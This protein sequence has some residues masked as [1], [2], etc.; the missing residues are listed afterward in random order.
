MT[1][2]YR[3]HLTHLTESTRLCGSLCSAGRQPHLDL[4]GAQKPG[5]N[6]NPGNQDN[7]DSGDTGNATD[8]SGNMI[9][10]TRF[11]RVLEQ[12]KAAEAALKTVADELIQDIPDDMRDLV[13]A[14]APAEQIK[15][16]RTRFSEASS[17]RK[18]KADRMP[19]GPAAIAA[20]TLPECHS[21]GLWLQDT[22][23][24]RSNIP[25]HTNIIRNI[26]HADFTGSCK[27]CSRPLARGSNRNFSSGFSCS[28]RLPFFTSLTGL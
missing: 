20:P 9:P 3:Q 21:Q 13:P 28:E 10:K 12:K 26:Y 4:Q 11:N 17:P 1:W 15:W 2:H 24:P 5:D 23:R 27:T 6:Q 7:Q 19:G 22:R 16:I 14:I 25:Q 18:L 8:N